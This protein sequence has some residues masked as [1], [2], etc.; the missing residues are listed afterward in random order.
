[1]GFSIVSFSRI[2]GFFR[3][4]KLIRIEY[5]DLIGFMVHFFH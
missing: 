4:S 1:M 3:F 2:V 5:I